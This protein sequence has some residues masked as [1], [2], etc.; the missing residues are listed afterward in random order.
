MFEPMQVIL[1]KTT[2]TAL[3]VHIGKS[4]LAIGDSV[5]LR[6]MDDGQIGVIAKLTHYRLGL[7]PY[8]AQT[9]VGLIP[10]IDRA[11]LLPHMSGAETMRVRIVTL[12][13]EHLAPD[14]RAELAVSVWGVMRFV[15]APTASRPAVKTAPPPEPAPP[16]PPAAIPPPPPFRKA[17]AG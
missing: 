9:L 16:E 4:G 14:R 2:L 5:Y 15:R 6:L 8:K 7:F 10:P 12:T 3:Q 11:S 17:S 1:A 13:P